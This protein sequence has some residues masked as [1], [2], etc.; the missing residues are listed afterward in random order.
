MCCM[1]DQVSL[2]ATYAATLPVRQRRNLYAGFLRSLEGDEIRREA[3]ELAE[4]HMAGDVPAILKQVD[5]TPP[6]T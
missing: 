6:H 4:E 3:L 2:V 1:N 5:W